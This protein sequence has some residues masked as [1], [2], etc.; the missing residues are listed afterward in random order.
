MNEELEKIEE[1]ITDFWTDFFKSLLFFLNQNQ[2]S[3]IVSFIHYAVF[4]VGFYYFFFQSK[5]GD[6]Y[7][8]VFFIF[9]VL[10]ALSYFIFNKCFFT[11]IE[12]NLSNN[13]KNPIQQLMDNYFGKEIEGNITSK[14]ILSASSI[15]IGLTLLKDYGYLN[16]GSNR[17]A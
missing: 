6:I 3:I 2:Q 12:L 7:R 11:S 4:I 13:E 9:V 14:V 15:V 16:W 10:G 1:K 17:D 5:P 8:I